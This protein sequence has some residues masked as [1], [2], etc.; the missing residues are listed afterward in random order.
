MYK[1]C[2][3]I[4]KLYDHMW[5]QRNVQNL[6]VEG[7]RKW[8]IPPYL[9]LRGRIKYLMTGDCFIFFWNLLLFDH[10]IWLFFFVCNRVINYLDINF[11]ECCILLIIRSNI[12][13]RKKSQSHLYGNVICD[14]AFREVGVWGWYVVFTG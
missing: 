6:L 7:V 9:N 1:T 3:W 13:S 11:F 14:S 12:V 10:S 4:V 2:V 5:P 8:E